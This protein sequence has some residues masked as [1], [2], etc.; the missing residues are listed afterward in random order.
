[1][2][3]YIAGDQGEALANAS[4]QAV[5][6]TVEGTQ[7][8]SGVKA[9]VTGPAVTDQRPERSRPRQHEND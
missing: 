8:P 7:A 6:D 4:V 3:V 2:Q 5:R 9:Y 1:M